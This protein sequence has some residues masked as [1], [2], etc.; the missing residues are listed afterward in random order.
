MLARE[1]FLRRRDTTGDGFRRRW[2]EFGFT[3]GEFDCRAACST[4]ESNKGK[5]DLWVGTDQQANLGASTDHAVCT[6]IFPRGY[7]ERMELSRSSRHD[8]WHNSSK[9]MSWKMVRVIRIGNDR[10]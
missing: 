3:H 5:D 6:M 7:S 10:V 4:S 1:F 9:M 8:A 2:S